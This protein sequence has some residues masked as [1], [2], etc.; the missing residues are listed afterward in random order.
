MSGEDLIGD[1]VAR[2]QAAEDAVVADRRATIATATSACE[3]PECRVEVHAT[4]HPEVAGE[5]EDQLLEI[6][7]EGRVG[8]HLDAEILEDRAAF[9]LGHRHGGVADLV[10][11]HAGLVGPL[12]EVDDG[13]HRF[14]FVETVGP[15]GEVRAVGEIFGDENL[16]HRAEKPS[17]TAG[18]DTQ[19][20][21]GDLGRLGDAR[22][23]DDERAVGIVRH[24]LDDSAS[25]RDPVRVPGILA[26]EH[27]A[28]GVFH[29]GG[30]VA[31]HRAKKL[32]VDPEL[33]GLLLGERV[34][35][36]LHAEGLAGGS[37]V[38]AGQVVALAAAAV[39]EDRLTAV[40]VAD[41]RQA[42]GD[43]ANRRVPVDLLKGAVVTSPHRACEPVWVVL[44]VVE[45]ECLLAGVALTDGVV[46]VAAD[47]G[48]R[49]PI[50]GEFDL[51]TAVDAAE[52]AGRLV[53]HS[54][55]AARDGCRDVLAARHGSR[56]AHPDSGFNK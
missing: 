54:L 3:F 50:V 45:A 43:F 38:A 16:E 15:F 46:L 35:G 6:A 8:G 32:S 11:G 26:E 17:V 49:A 36:V 20:D 34:R 7:I 41:L 48:E 5:D 56:L 21:V 44:V 33:A 24:L 2:H 12:V 55:G 28:G 1:A 30:G 14:E 53:P 4:L 42:G 51:D 47:A 39:I 40:L 13:E 22:V 25:P 9:G 10:E 52:V 27:P 31:R 19:V 23:D 18:T 37:G 29:V